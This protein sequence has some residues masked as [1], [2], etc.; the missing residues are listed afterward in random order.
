MSPINEIDDFEGDLNPM[1][2]SN[3]VKVL[4]IITGGLRREGIASTQLEFFKHMDLEKIKISVAAVHDNSPEMIADFENNNCKV[5]SFPDR[6]S[7]TLKYFLSLIHTM[8]EIN[9]DIVHVHG[10]SAIMSIELLA[11]KLAG[12]KI[13]IAHS[14]NTKA[15]NIQKDRLLRPM[16]EHLYTMGMACGQE[17]G[18]WL[19]GTR[20]FVVIH[21]GKDF[22]KFKYDAVKRKLQ[23]EKL[24]LTKK[25]VVGHVG[26]IN[27]QK[28]HEFLIRAFY[29]FQKE[30]DNAVL[31]L[32][33][34]GPL[35]DE[36]KQQA[37]ELGISDKVIFTG[38]VND[39]PDRLQ[40]MDIMVFPSKYEGL[41]N[42]VLEWQAEGLPCLI[43]DKITKEC[44]PSDLVEFA[45]IEDDPKV[46][47]NKMEEMLKKFTDRETQAKCGTQALKEN[48][49]DIVDATKQLENI[50]LKLAHQ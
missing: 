3:M 47:A 24:G 39:V 22:Q 15:D 43:S 12:V 35:I 28:N 10:S 1:R 26:R 29:E 48:G 6:Q 33:G 34:G 4:H 20:P 31:Y 19:F 27:G 49:F 32:I 13:R 16:F 25:I 2:R 23:R 42:V 8:K 30:N 38:S 44:A 46:W 21:N 45:S 50:Y 9:P 18:E 36:R 11:A 7:D 17:A 5:Y 14:R 41:P 40:A 37:E